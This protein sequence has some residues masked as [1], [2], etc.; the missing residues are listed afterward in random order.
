MVAVFVW[1]ILLPTGLTLLPQVNTWD[2][3]VGL[4]VI[5]AMVD[6]VIETT[7][8]TG[9]LIAIVRRRVADMRGTAIVT[10]GTV[11]IGEN[12]GVRPQLVEV[13][14]DTRPIIGTGEAIQEAH[15]EEEALAAI[16]SQTV[17]VVLASPQQMVQIHVGEVDAIPGGE[18][19]I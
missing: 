6:T 17:R 13:A 9:T 16:G 18:N 19:R 15:R 2:T 3:D 8:I 1:I 4:P 10:E 11:E 12:A 7:G 5:P 14:E